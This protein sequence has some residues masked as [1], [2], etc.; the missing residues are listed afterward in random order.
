M[1][2]E[3]DKPEEPAQIA[4]SGPTGR[5]SKAEFGRRLYDMI[6]ARGW[7]QSE[8][9]R[10]ANVQRDGISSY[11]NGKT[12]PSDQNLVK[13]ARALG[14][15]PNDLMPDFGMSGP[16]GVSSDFTVEALPGDPAMVRIRLD[17]VLPVGI[18]T[19]IVVL[20]NKHAANRK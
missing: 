9:A 12:Y 15:K 10:R 1:Q 3:N 2:A 7:R 5:I 6:L 13:I 18:A 16:A 20:V 8:L 19:E 4:S 14:V 11:I 17:R